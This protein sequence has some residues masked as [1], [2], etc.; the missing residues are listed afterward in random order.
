MLANLI[1]EG[2]DRVGKSTLVAALTEYECV[3]LLAPT[4]RSN[5]FYQ[6]LT[7]FTKINGWIPESTRPYVFDRGHISE[8]V[9]GSLYRP[10]DY[11]DQILDHWIASMEAQVVL[12]ARKFPIRPTV[13]V[14]VE[15][16][17]EAIMLEDERENSDRAKELKT[18]EQM[19]ERSH[20]PIV[21]I[22]T[23][24]KKGWKPVK[25]TISELKELING[26]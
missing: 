6:Y 1:I 20:L 10:L 18:Y 21:R 12:N 15:P 24:T 25:Q 26:Y 3:K 22:T 13:I 19:L 14:Y 17:N 11:E 2:V 8:L 16:V 4:S 9:Y 5:T 23:Q 7:F